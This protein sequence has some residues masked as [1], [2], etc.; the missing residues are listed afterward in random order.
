[1][2]LGVTLHT[3]R[4][5]RRVCRRSLPCCS[6]RSATGI[7]YILVSSLHLLRLIRRKGKSTCFDSVTMPETTPNPGINFPEWFQAFIQATHAVDPEESQTMPHNTGE[8]LCP[9][10]C[11][12]AMFDQPPPGTDPKFIHDDDRKRQSLSIPPTSCLVTDQEKSTNFPLDF[13][14]LLEH[15]ICSTTAAS[16]DGLVLFIKGPC[17]T[18]KFS[19]L[20]SRPDFWNSTNRM[21]SGTAQCSTH[22][23]PPRPSMDQDTWRRTA[24]RTR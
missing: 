7:P 4:H 10:F 2:E 23:P 20:S 22:Y 11:R 16:I 19:W 6:S 14:V 9:I 24:R 17:N 13:P 5:P 15:R 8:H 21:K 12:L 3:R 1:M 18:T